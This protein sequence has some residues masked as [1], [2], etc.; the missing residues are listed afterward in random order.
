[1]T[2]I[3]PAK[4]GPQSIFVVLHILF[5]LHWARARVYIIERFGAQSIKYYTIIS[6]IPMN[7]VI[8]DDCFFE[9][10]LD[11]SIVEGRIRF[12]DRYLRQYVHRNQLFALLRIINCDAE[13]APTTIMMMMSM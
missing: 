2:A 6:I 8:E 1:M 9:L 11:R 5:Y 4:T 7:N 3:V 10:M 12:G 13:M